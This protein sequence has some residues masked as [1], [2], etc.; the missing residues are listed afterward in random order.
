MNYHTNI[1]WKNYCLIKSIGTPSLLLDEDLLY[2]G[3]DRLNV[4]DLYTEENVLYFK[5]QHQ[6]LILS[7]QGNI[8]NLAVI[9]RENKKELWIS[10]NT[11]ISVR[12]ILMEISFKTF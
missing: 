3:T 2:I 5:I 10:L 6:D 4:L 1:Y 11:G 8:N 12:L 7:Y 9:I